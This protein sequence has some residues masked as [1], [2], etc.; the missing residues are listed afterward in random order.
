MMALWANV[1]G[2]SVRELE[3]EGGRESEKRNQE[4]IENGARKQIMGPQ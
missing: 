3:R 4:V 1:K 2:K